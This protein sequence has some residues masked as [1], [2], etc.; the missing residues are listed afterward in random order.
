[1]YPELFTI[2]GITVY[3]YGVCVALGFF[4]ALQYVIKYS[5]NAGM[6]KSQIYDFFFYIIIAGIIGARLL[7]V[8]IEIKYFISNPLEIFQLWKGGLVYYGGF[9]VAAAVAAV[10][11]KAKK[12]EF[13]VIVDLLA[14][15]LALGHFFGRIGCFFSGCCYGKECDSFIAVHNRYPTQLT[16]AFFNLVIFFILH[17]INSVKHKPGLTFW[18]YLIMYPVLRF[19]VEFFRGDDRGM[20]FLGLSIGQ[21]ISLVMMAAAAA[22]IILKYRKAYEKK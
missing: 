4:V 20:F 16:E 18:T 8:L 9:I 3:T 21:I 13:P 19:T 15:A 2:G 14:P 12:I 6:S 7:Y 11:L 22:V 10:Y 1:M 5:S 17:K